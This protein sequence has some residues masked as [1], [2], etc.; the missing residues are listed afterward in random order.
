MTITHE[1]GL[2]SPSDCYGA[3][4]TSV[5]EDEKGLWAGNE[6]YWSQVNYCPVCGYKAKKQVD[7]TSKP[8]NKCGE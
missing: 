4:V 6:E 8:V 1:C 7:A 3:A 2:N 5:F